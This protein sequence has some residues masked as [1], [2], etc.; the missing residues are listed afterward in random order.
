[1]D[2]KE[3]KTNEDSEINEFITKNQINKKDFYNE[4]KIIYSKNIV[5]FNRYSCQPQ[6]TQKM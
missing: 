5:S 4:I 2:N 6:F 3:D 1:M